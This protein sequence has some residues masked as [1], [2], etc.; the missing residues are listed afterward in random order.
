MTTFGTRVSNGHS[1]R[2]LQCAG[3]PGHWRSLLECPFVREESLRTRG[4]WCPSVTPSGLGPGEMRRLR[5]RGAAGHEA[6]RT[7]RRLGAHIYP[8]R[9]GASSQRAPRRL[10]ASSHVRT[11]TRAP[12][13]PT[14]GPTVFLCGGKSTVVGAD[15]G[16]RGGRVVPT[17]FFALQTP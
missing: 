17:Q 11:L 10:G 3:W 13:R 12:R 8:R 15:H 14:E 4:A 16:G 5:P 7:P 2:D 9:L 1:R 6:P